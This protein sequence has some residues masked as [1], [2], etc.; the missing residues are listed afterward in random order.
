MKRVD[1]ESPQISWIS[2]IQEEGYLGEKW[3][4]EIGWS[5]LF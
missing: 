4:R 5:Q 1:D 3:P 2:S